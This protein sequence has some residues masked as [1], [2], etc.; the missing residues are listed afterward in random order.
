MRVC[1]GK[2]ALTSPVLSSQIDRVIFCVS[3]DTDLEMYTHLLR[4]YFP[5]GMYVCAC[6][7]ESVCRN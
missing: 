6:R 3:L 1:T 4:K 2:S 7:V 5:I